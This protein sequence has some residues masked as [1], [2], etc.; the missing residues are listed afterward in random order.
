MLNSFEYYKIMDTEPPTYLED[1]EAL[2]GIKSNF[3]IKSWISDPCY[4][5]PWDG[6]GC[7]KSSSVIRISEIN[8][9][10]MNLTGSIPQS[11]GR[12]TA[13][14]NVSLDNNQLTGPLPNF[15]S[16]TMLERLHLR[17]N[18]LSGGLPEW[19]SELKNL[20]ELFIENNNFTGVIPVRL[21]KKPSLKLNYS[22]NHDLCIHMRRGKCIVSDSRKDKASIVL[23]TAISG[24]AIM[25]LLVMV[26][27]AVHRKKFR[28]KNCLNKDYSMTMPPNPSMSS[29]FSLKEM[30]KA[31]ENFSRKIGQG[32]FGSVFF[33]KLPGGKEIAVKVLSLFSKQGIHEFQNE[34]DLLSRVHHKNLVSL[35]GYCNESKELMLIYEHMSGGSLRDH[36]Y[37]PKAGISELNWKTRLKIALDAAQGL[38]YLHLGCTPQIIHRDVKTANI[39]LDSNLKGKLAD[40]G[41]SRMAIDEEATHVTTTVKG[42]AGYLD[43][44]YFRTQKLT[45]RSDVYSFGVVLLEIL[46]GRPPINPNLPEDEINLIQWVKPYVENGSAEE[47][48]EVIDGRLGGNYD[49]KSITGIAKLALRC[50]EAKPSSRPSVSEVVADIKEAIIHENENNAPLPNPEVIG[51]ECGDLQCMPGCSQV[52]AMAW[53]DNS[54]NLPNEGR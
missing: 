17:N 40:F 29:A 53:G 35:L 12:L 16:L 43:P 45:E 32:G 51:I 15:S 36:L 2:D 23:G 24:A 39:L 19:L 13:L 5:I 41:L 47:I 52:D 4:V 38:E 7:D 14:V 48:A 22:G 20:K 42:T 18:N 30:T 37:G 28:E 10:G 54:S 44:E 34:V 8:L 6:I 27:I 50:V 21:L 11:I 31:T 25:V 3:D 46:C 1:I 33:G 9:S 49:M 26:C